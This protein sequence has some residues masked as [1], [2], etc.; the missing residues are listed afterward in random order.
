M[1]LESPDL[2]VLRWRRLEVVQELYAEFIPFLEEVMILLGFS[3]T[4]IQADIAKFIAYGPAY[5]M[6]MAQRGQAKTTICAAFAVWS[7]IHDPRHRILIISAGGAQASDISTL[8]I[9]IIM[10]MPELECLRPDTTAGDRSSVEHFDV[11]HTLK[12]VDKSPSVACIGITGQL[13]GKRADLLIADDVESTK[14]STTAVQ[15]AQLLHLTLDFTSINSTGRI[16]WLGTPQTNESIYNTLPSRGVTIRIWPGRYPTSEQMENYGEHLAPLLRRRL[17][18]NSDLGTGGGALG[19]QGK[20]VDPKLMNEHILQSKERD[21]GT[22]Y[23]QLQHM[24]NTRLIDALRYPLKTIALVTMAMQKRMP[25]E[26]VRGL[27]S[28]TARDWSIHGYAFRTQTPL[29]LSPETANMQG[30]I[31][32]VDPAGGG[33]NADETAYATVGFLNGN[34][35]L[36]DAGG[37]PGGYSKENMEALATRLAYWQPSKV[38]I[39][40][41]MGYG[42]FREVFTP[43]LVAA[44]KCEIEDDYVSGQKE[45]RIIATLEPVLGRGALI[46]NQDVIERDLADC[47]RYIPAMRASYSLFFQLAKI[48]KERQALVH[49]DR[50]DALEGAVRYWQNYVALNQRHAVERQREREHAEELKNIMGYH[51]YGEP[52]GRTGSVFNRFRKL[53]K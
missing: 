8:V 35:F 9:R 37:V 27:T 17:E 43:I 44:H 21:Q 53:R 42:A 33:A 16:I 19:D 10:T 45:Q 6:V 14:N 30:I 48:T 25:M 2:A 5:L 11:H 41:N 20:P 40:K 34:L 31:S 49:D 52:A 51:R 23:F 7:L 22:S 46:V 50:V 13:Q 29:E 24:L 38:I 4:E 32:Y 39:E 28:N 15:R 12:G 26:I 3:T 36:L 18:F 47:N 1:A